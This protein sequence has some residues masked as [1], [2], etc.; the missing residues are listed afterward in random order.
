MV[1]VTAH[2]D[3]VCVSLALWRSFQNYVKKTV[4]IQNKNMKPKKVEDVATVYNIY[5]H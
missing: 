1:G 4:M 2:G 5:T 3:T